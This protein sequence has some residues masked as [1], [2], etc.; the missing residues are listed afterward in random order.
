MHL[1][2]LT[3]PVGL[4]HLPMQFAA[5]SS[6]RI[7]PASA[8]EW[9]TPVPMRV[10]AKKRCRVMVEP[11]EKAERATLNPNLSTRLKP[12]FFRSGPFAHRRA[13]GSCAVPR[14]DLRFRANRRKMCNQNNGASRCT[15]RAWIPALRQ[16]AYPGM[17]EAL[18][19]ILPLDAVLTALPVL[20]SRLC[21]PAV[22]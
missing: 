14:P 21:H 1:L 4:T 8:G 5:L 20:Q 3:P 12:T 18:R 11:P 15:D 6:H 17:T 13:I 19:V 7:A 2:L 9:S 10:I 22:P 16:A